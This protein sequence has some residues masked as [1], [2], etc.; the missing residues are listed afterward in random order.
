MFIT[1]RETFHPPSIG[2]GHPHP[3]FTG[4]PA[5]ALQTSLDVE[6][7]EEN[8]WRVELNSQENLVELLLGAD[9]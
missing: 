7:S 8:T 5:K 3:E 6:F 4:P 2:A 9:V 1:G